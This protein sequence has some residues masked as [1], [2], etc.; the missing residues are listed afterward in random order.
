MKTLQEKLLAFITDIYSS[1]DCLCPANVYNTAEKLL[2]EANKE[3]TVVRLLTYTGPKAVVE[4]LLSL[5]GVKLAHSVAYNGSYVL[6]AEQFIN[7]PI[8]AYSACAE[9]LP[10]PD[11]VTINPKFT[12]TPK[13][14]DKCDIFIED[15]TEPQF[16]ALQKFIRE[17]NLFGKMPH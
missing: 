4:A 14:T 1:K 17:N 10:L 13:P 15:L 9:V 2:S 7:E 3:I 11:T 5:R 16:K 6:I 8:E 12:L